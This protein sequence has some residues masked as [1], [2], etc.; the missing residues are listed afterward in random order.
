MER[1]SPTDARAWAASVRDMVRKA[2]PDAELCLDG[3]EWVVETAG[4]Q[5]VVLG[6]RV[7]HRIC[8]AA[9]FAIGV[10]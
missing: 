4:G 8:T 2:D 1:V 10:A 5:R 9:C 6:V 7:V 3:E